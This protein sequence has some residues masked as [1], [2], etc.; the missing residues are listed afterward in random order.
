M[1]KKRAARQPGRNLPGKTELNAR[2]RAASA[3]RSS[4]LRAPAPRAKQPLPRISR[5][6]FRPRSARRR[7]ARSPGTA[8]RRSQPGTRAG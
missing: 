2:R 6:L 7:A 8:A 1:A 4:T 3:P 5:K